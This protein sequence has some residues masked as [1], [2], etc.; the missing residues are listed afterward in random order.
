MKDTGIYLNDRE[1]Y[2]VDEICDLFEV[3]ERTVRQWIK[4]GKLKT[5]QPTRR[6]LIS[7]ESLRMFLISGNITE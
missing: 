2:R 4:D 1:F 7:S 3:T 6:H 5:F